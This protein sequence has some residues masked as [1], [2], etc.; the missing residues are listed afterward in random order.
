MQNHIGINLQAASTFF[1]K[2][3]LPHLLSRGTECANAHA[4]VMMDVLA[5]LVHPGTLGSPQ[6]S[7]KQV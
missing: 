4:Y 5:F 1:E 6:L 3:P 2:T 7:G